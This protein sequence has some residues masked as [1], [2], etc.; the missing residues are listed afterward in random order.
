MGVSVPQ[1]H[2]IRWMEGSDQL[3]IE[4]RPKDGGEQTR[5]HQNLSMSGHPLLL[6][7]MTCVATYAGLGRLMTLHT[8]SHRNVR[9]LVQANL[10]GNVPVALLASDAVGEMGFVTEGHEGRQL[11]DSNPRNG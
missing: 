7:L 1:Q 5:P 2:R 6:E 10:L 4:A 11:I 3:Q 8:A 9:S